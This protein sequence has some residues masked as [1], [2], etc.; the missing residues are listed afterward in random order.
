MTHDSSHSSRSGIDTAASEALKGGETDVARPGSGS[1]SATDSVAGAHSASA[2]DSVAGAHSISATDSVAGAHSISATDS[3]AGAHSNPDRVTSS[4]A[5]LNGAHVKPEA[6]KSSQTTEGDDEQWHRGK[7]KWFNDA[8]GFGFIVDA[9]AG[10][11]FVHYSVIQCDGFK[12]LKEGELVEYLIRVGEKGNQASIVKRNPDEITG[13]NTRTIHERVARVSDRVS[14][15]NTATQAPGKSRR[16][17]KPQPGP[18]SKE[19]PA[20]FLGKS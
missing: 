6:T 18:S 9:R 19:H 15:E 2:T 16:H 7:V 13:K 17:D 5:E 4:A 10:D 8:K 11:V 3:V 20:Q 12:T 14:R 1:I